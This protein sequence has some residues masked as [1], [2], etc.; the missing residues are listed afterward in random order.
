ML[1]SILDSSSTHYTKK[2][3]ISSHEHPPLPHLSPTVNPATRPVEKS[4][5]PFPPALPASTA[6]P[7]HPLA[8]SKLARNKRPTSCALR[9]P[10][11]RPSPAC[12]V[13]NSVP[14]STPPVKK[15]AS[16]SNLTNRS[17]SILPPRPSYPSPMPSV[18]SPHLKLYMECIRLLKVEK[19]MRPRR[20]T[21]RL[22]QRF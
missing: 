12:L 3:S 15:I 18:P 4:N 20:C 17:N 10:A 5:G 19:W 7:I 22:G 14:S 11:N 13:V 8:G 9:N 2:S 6:T 16:P 1:K 21:W